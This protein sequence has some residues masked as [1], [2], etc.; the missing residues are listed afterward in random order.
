MNKPIRN[1]ERDYDAEFGIIIVCCNSDWLFA[2]A[3]CASVRYFMPD[4][5]ICLLIDG[6]I[7]TRLLKKLYKVKTIERKNI[8][9]E[10]LIK[11]SYGYGYTKLISLWYSPFK[12][13]FLLD[14]D[15][16]VWGDFNFLKMPGVDV[17]LD[18][19]LSE[20]NG[21]AVNSWFFDTEKMKSI[22]PEFDWRKHRNSYV[23]SGA[24]RL[25]KHLLPVSEYLSYLKIADETNVFRMGEQ[26][27][28]N[29]MWFNAY[30]KG[31][32]KLTT[33]PI[34]IMMHDYAY[35]D[36]KAR[37]AFKDNK[38]IVN[39]NRVLHYPGPKPVRGCASYIEPMLFFRRQYFKDAYNLPVWFSDVIIYKEDNLFIF[40]R[41][42]RRVRSKLKKIFS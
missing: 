23:N 32:I 20:F 3:C 10:E 16:V 29:Y 35:D 37:F 28:F 15:T 17:V 7:N 33:E 14:A 38:P 13:F 34:Q 22:F 18:K 41:F 19:Q 9:N 11:H 21:E 4:V 12:T 42:K 8:D 5:E 27:L 39:E 24:S 25:R 36:L 26:G 1:D 31:E 2:K 6:E 30:E 40:S